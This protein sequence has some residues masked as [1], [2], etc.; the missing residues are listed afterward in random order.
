[1]PMAADPHAVEG[2]IGCEKP[3]GNRILLSFSG[4][5]GM[6]FIYFGILPSILSIQR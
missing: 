4:I 2:L 6:I 5:F 1:M 3:L